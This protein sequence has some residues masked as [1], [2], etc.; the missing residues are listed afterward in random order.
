MTTLDSGATAEA[1][2]SQVGQPQWPANGLTVSGP[3]FR[4]LVAS[5]A[6]TEAQTKPTM[7][8]PT[9]AQAELAAFAVTATISDQ[10]IRFGVGAQAVT[11]PP[12]SFYACYRRSRTYFTPGGH[13]F[14]H[15]MG[16]LGIE[17]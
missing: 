3:L 8:D 15:R 7:A 4:A 2:V 5:P 14:G 12:P 9:L 6:T 1:A 10:A 11:P 13:P 16:T 17:C